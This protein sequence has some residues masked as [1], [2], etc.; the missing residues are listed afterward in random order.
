MS[1]AGALND[2]A[3]IG[4][5]IETITGNTGGAVGPDGAHNVNFTGNGGFTVTGVPA[6]NALTV[7]PTGFTAGSVIFADSATSFTQDNASFFW[8]NSAKSLYLTSNTG[9]D[10]L[11]LRFDA[12]TYT[13]FTMTAAGYLEISNVGN[14]IRTDAAMVIGS[15]ANNS[16]FAE[17]SVFSTKSYGVD[18]LGQLAEDTNGNGTGATAAL[19]AECFLDPALGASIGTAV[20]SNPNFSLTGGQTIA[21]GSCIHAAPGWSFN[22]GTVTLYAGLYVSSGD[23]LGGGTVDTAYGLYVEESAV[24]TTKYGAYIEGSVGIATT[25]PAALLSIANGANDTTNYGRAIQITNSNGN[26]Q[27]ISFIRFGNN[28]ISCGYEGASAIWGFGTGTGTDA[29]FSPTFLSMDANNLRIGIGNTSPQAKLEVTTNTAQVYGL[30]ISGTQQGDDTGNSIALLMDAT[31][32]PTNNGIRAVGA[33]MTPT[34]AVS[35]T[36]TMPT[37]YGLYVDPT[38]TVGSGA[39]TDAVTL[40]VGEPGGGTNRYSAVFE[41]AVGIGT[42]SPTSILDVVSSSQ[43]FLFVPN[44]PNPFISVTSSSGQ[45]AGLGATPSSDGGVTTVGSISNHGLRIITNDTTRILVSSAGTVSITT[46]SAPIAGLNGLHM[47]FNANVANIEATQSGT[48]NRLM[49]IGANGLTLNVANGVLHSAFNN[50]GSLVIGSGA[51]ATT[52][53]NGFLY[54][55]SCPGAP[56]GTPTANT[57]RVPMVYDSSNDAFYIYNGAW[58]SVTLT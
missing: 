13:I 30:R 20:L 42:T 55:P 15:L 24:G 58:R 33:W 38:F 1:Q 43:Q 27:Q 32:Q 26:S 5:D 23:P 37:A 51:L 44:S 53:T 56:T 39:I 21:I 25:A 9:A 35:S 48:A 29:S 31:V 46:G 18:I 19:M 22:S 47:Y 12:S 6:S 45:V 28:V 4:G 16:D 50:L 54:I 11:R 49:Q 7:T 57:G 36:N 41:G 34:L 52:A 17:V 2:N 8:D 14:E 10:Q 40:F 3:T